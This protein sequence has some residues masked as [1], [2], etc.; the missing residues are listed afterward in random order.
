[1]GHERFSHSNAPDSVND[2]TEESLLRG[3]QEIMKPE[4]RLCLHPTHLQF[5]AGQLKK[6]FGWTDKMIA[7]QNAENG[8]VVPVPDER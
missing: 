3:I 6:Y 5:T 7:A 4:T 2:L 8:V 1:M